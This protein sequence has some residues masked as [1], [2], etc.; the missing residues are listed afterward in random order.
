MK[1]S[2]VIA[3]TMAAIFATGLALSGQ[4]AFAAPV[5]VEIVSGAAN[6]GDKAFSPNPV[7]AKVGDTVTWTNTDTALHTVTQGDATNGA[8]AGGF[9]SKY[10]APKKAFSFTFDKEGNFAYYCQLHPTMVGMVKVGAGESAMEKSSASVTLDGKSYTVTGES[11]GVKVTAV[12]IKPN[13]EVGVQF[14]GSGDVELTLPKS[15]ISGITSVTAGGQQVSF[16]EESSTSTDTTIKLTLPSGASS[17]VI[18]G[19]TVVP[20]FS[21]IAALVFAA[22]LMAAIGFARFRGSSFGLRF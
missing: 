19:A 1:A 7:E 5:N 21:V 17:V 11:S 6:L 12:T 16:T 18:K 13:E 9:D 3:A 14:A 8:T 20:E 2:T 15:M 22:S 4:N 10:L